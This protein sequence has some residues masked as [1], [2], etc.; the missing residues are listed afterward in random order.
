MA[1]DLLKY[2]QYTV[3][4]ASLFYM[5]KILKDWKKGIFSGLLSK[6]HNILF[7]YI[8]SLQ[9]SAVYLF[10]EANGQVTEIFPAQLCSMELYKNRNITVP[11]F[12]ETVIMFL[13]LIPSS[14]NTDY[15][16]GD[17]LK[18]TREVRLIYNRK[19]PESVLYLMVVRQ[20]MYKRQKREHGFA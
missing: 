12:L 16:I 18:T 15:Q 10:H 3:R 1:D 8:F 6:S 4:H 19:S 2:E 20:T 5:D 13:C 17:T 11:A 14:L 9:V 7:A